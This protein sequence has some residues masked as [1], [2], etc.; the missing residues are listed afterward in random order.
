[1]LN[2]KSILLMSFVIVLLTGCKNTPDLTDS[3]SSSS[4]D[5]ENINN[6][7]IIYDDNTESKENPLKDYQELIDNYLAEEVSYYTIKNNIL[8]PVNSEKRNPYSLDATSDEIEKITN[9]IVQA[10]ADAIGCDVDDENFHYCTTDYYASYATYGR[11]LYRYLH[12]E[13]FLEVIY[14]NDRLGYAHVYSNR[15]VTVGLFGQRY[16]DFLDE[17]KSLGLNSWKE[18]YD[19][20]MIFYGDEFDTIITINLLTDEET[21]LKNRKTIIGDPYSETDGDFAGVYPVE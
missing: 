12:T 8:Y 15:C 20:D 18:I 11:C 5:N 10:T 4:Y 14:E 16:Y 1:M 13:N 17:M 9:E 21:I 2:K 19:A 6:E 7:T 3:S